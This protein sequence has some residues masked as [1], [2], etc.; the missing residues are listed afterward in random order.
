MAKK[1][2]LTKKQKNI[3]VGD[4]DV[5]VRQIKALVDVPPHVRTG[6]TGGWVESED[7]LSHAGSAWI[8]DN[9]VACL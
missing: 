5:T 4:K 2:E 6:D 3:R 8:Y 9:A 1:Y 7:N